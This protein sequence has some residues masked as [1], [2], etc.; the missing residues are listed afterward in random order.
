MATSSTLQGLSSVMLNSSVS[1]PNSRD[2]P[3]QVWRDACPF[4]MQYD[5]EVCAAVDS[6][7]SCERRDFESR[8]TSKP[9]GPERI[10]SAST[11][12]FHITFFEIYLHGSEATRDLWKIGKLYNDPQRRWFRECAC[13]VGPTIVPWVLIV[14]SAILNILL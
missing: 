8:R 4:L 10:L 6:H 2:K 5:R 11:L 9:A 12:I 7:L 14:N 13:T 3:Y 1:R